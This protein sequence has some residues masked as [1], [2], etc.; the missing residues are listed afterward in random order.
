MRKEQLET[1]L[2]GV[3]TQLRTD[4]IGFTALDVE[5]NAIVVVLRDPAQMDDALKSLAKAEG[6]SDATT[7]GAA[8]QVS[9]NT[10]RTAIEAKLTEAAVQDRANKAVEQ[11]IEIVRRRIDQLGVTEPQIARQ[12]QDRILVQLPGVEDPDRVKAIIGT[13][14]KM[15]FRLLDDAADPATGHVPA[16][17]D[18]LPGDSSNQR[19]GMPNQYAVRKKIEVSGGD[20]I[21]A[22]PAT[23]Q[24]GRWVVS[25]EFNAHGAKRFAQTTLAN[26]G[27]PFAIVLDNKVISAPAIQ[28]PITGGAR[29]DQRQL[30]GAKCQRS[31]GVAARRCLAGTFEDYRR[32]QR[33]P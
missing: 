24:N 18:L 13:T 26:V 19:P 30:H 15:D 7:A 16:T 14:A 20:L 29:P 31:F 3:R 10:D 32:T 6:I 2:D 12:G 28:E 22:R 23:D 5:N 9:P 11:S 21:D 1:A 8:F 33:W 17:D 27:K 4:K 25:F